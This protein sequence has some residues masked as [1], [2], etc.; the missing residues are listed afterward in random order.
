MLKALWQFFDLA[1]RRV[2]STAIA[3]KTLENIDILS[4]KILKSICESAT[5]ERNLA[6]LGRSLINF[7]KSDGQSVAKIV[8]TM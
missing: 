5:Y 6:Q 3:L 1:H 8:L 4:M 2:D 7:N